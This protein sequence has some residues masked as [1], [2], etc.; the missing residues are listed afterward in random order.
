MTMLV[1][2]PLHTLLLAR[3]VPSRLMGHKMVHSGGFFEG[4]SLP[5]LFSRERHTMSGFRE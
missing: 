5:R 3:A 2:A 4:T 1:I